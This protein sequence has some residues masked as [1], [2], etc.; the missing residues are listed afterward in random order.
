MKR[1]WTS[2][3]P[4]RIRSHSLTPSRDRPAGRGRGSLTRLLRSLA[5]AV[6]V[7]AIGTEAVL[8]WNQEFAPVGTIGD[9]LNTQASPCVEW[10]KTANNLSVTVDEYLSYLLDAEEVNLKVDVRDSF[11]QYNPIA[12]R[13]P[14]LQETAST[15]NEEV[16]VTTALM[17]YNKYARTTVSYQSAAP[18]HIL[19]ALVEFN[20]YIEWNRSLNFTCY[21]DASHRDRCRADA[22]K[23]AN[24][25]QGHVEGLD[26]VPS[27]STAIMVQ[28]GTGFFAIQTDD[29]NGIISIYGAYP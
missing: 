25:E 5:F 3:G 22:R 27:G 10:P 6:A 4:R 26:H 18:Y 19:S 20:S 1:V 11:A 7:T 8:A 13:N 21:V 28:G 29:R 14:H 23:V 12:A 9:C 2:T 15:T 24:H 16:W 17:D